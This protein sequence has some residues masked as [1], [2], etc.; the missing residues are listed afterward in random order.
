[1]PGVSLESID[2]PLLLLLAQEDNSILEIGN[3]LIRSNFQA[4]N[5]PTWLVEFADAG[6]WSFSDICDIVDDLQPGCGEGVRQTRPGTSFTYLDNAVA[7]DIAAS[8]VT[9]FFAAQLLDDITA[10][11]AL[12]V[13]EP[14]DVVTVSVRRE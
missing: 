7:R 10:D 6:H 12:D 3:G 11:A 14:A 1:L 4:A 9:L 13:G 5:P 2:E 8:Y